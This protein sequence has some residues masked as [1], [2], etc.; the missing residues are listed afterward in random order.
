[1]T[2]KHTKCALALQEMQMK[3]ARTRESNGQHGGRGRQ[4]CT[5]GLRGAEG[6]GPESSSQ[7][8][9]VH[10]DRCLLD[11]LWRPLCNIYINI[12]HIVPVKLTQCHTSIISKLKKTQLNYN[13]NCQ[14]GSDQLSFLYRTV[15]IQIRTFSNPDN[16]KISVSCFNELFT[17]F[18]KENHHEILFYTH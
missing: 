12:D 15:L 6:A 17:L 3:T 2:N 13:K 8:N 5:A 10:R 7:E 1:M 11:L 14:F 18:F 16:I 9:T 4:H